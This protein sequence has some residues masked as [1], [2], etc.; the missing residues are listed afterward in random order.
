MSSTRR[1][2]GDWG[3]TR[4]RG[5]LEENGVLVERSVGPGIVG[6]ATSPAAA[7]RTLLDP[8]LAAGAVDQIV[9]CGMVGSRN[10]LVEVPYVQAPVDTQRWLQSSAPHHSGGLALTIAPGV[11]GSNAAG[12]PDVMRGEETQIFGAFD[13]EPALK[14]GRHLLLLPGTHSKWVDVNEGRIERFQTFLTGELFALLSERSSLL[15]AAAAKGAAA[16]AGAAADGVD[17]GFMAGVARARAAGLAESLFETRSA[18]LRQSRSPEWAAGF[19]SGLLIGNEVATMGRALPPVGAMRSEA[20]STGGAGSGVVTVIGDPKLSWRYRQALEAR[21]A[22]VQ[23]LDG[24]HCV[25][26]GLRLLASYS[27]VESSK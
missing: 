19:L 18:Q 10:G 3:S 5:Y 1:M 2:L 23:E 4:L 7:L 21:G 17:A 6:L 9:L 15:S 22:V 12:A 20:A 11:T 26:A 16:A 24:D 25:I 27:C 14:A 8:W 13:V